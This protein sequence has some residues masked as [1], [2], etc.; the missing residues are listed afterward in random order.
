M[1]KKNNKFS[2]TE[3]IVISALLPEKDSMNNMVIGRDIE[4][5]IALS[6]KEIEASKYT[7]VQAAG[8]ISV[9]WDASCKI[10]KDIEFSGIEKALLKELIRKKDEEKNIDKT[11]LDV[12][13][14]IQ[15][16]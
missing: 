1:E 16:L 9:N 8:Q 12:Y 6:Q 4:K 11:S 7:S 14:R 3:R 5:K 13:Q 2:I 15:G 10:M